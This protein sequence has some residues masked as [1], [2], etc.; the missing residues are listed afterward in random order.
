[1]IKI[2]IL[3]YRSKTPWKMG[4]ATFIYGLVIVVVIIAIIDPSSEPTSAP[5]DVS[6]LTMEDYAKY[7]VNDTL[8]EKT[9]TQKI[10]FISASG[11]NAN[12]AININASENLTTSLQRTGILA[13]SIDVYKKAFAERPGLNSLKLN[14]YLDLVDQKGNESS[15]VV[16]RLMV[17]RK[18]AESIN[19]DNVIT[20]NIPKIVDEYWEHPLFSR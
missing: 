12:I 4:I 11:D 6:S 7:L 16:V 5:V 9:N 10:A 8:G 19:W 2:K 17:T 3:G 14:W 15:G 20:D 18:N 1:M 13:D